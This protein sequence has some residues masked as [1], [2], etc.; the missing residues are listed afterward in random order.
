MEGIINPKEANK[1]PCRSCGQFSGYRRDEIENLNLN[2]TEYKKCICC[3][4]I[5]IKALGSNV[6]MEHIIGLDALIALN[7]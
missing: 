5:C 2:V 6:V 7:L 1:I 3:G 4:S